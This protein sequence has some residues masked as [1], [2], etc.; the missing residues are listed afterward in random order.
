MKRLMFASIAT[1]LLTADGSVT[2]VPEPGALV[3]LGSGLASL[4]LWR[5]RRNR[6]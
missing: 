6:A 1:L 2:V 5:H 3:L 4:G